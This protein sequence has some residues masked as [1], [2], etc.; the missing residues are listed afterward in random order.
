MDLSAGT[1]EFLDRYHAAMPSDFFHRGVAAQRSLYLSLSDVFPYP[2]PEGVDVVDL[3]VP[4]QT[5]PIRFRVYRPA[6]HPSRAWL[7]YMHGGGFVVGSVESHDTLVAELAANTGLVTVSVEFRLAPEN[8]FPAALEDCREV[9]RAITADPT[10]IGL[11]S[12]ASGPVVCGD[13][14]GANL[15]VCLSVMCRDQDEAMPV[16]QGLI[17]PVLDFARWYD[18]DPSESFGE[19]MRYYTR[20]YCPSRDVA[21]HAYVSPLLSA[22]LTGLPPAYVMSTEYDDLRSDATAYAERL[23]AAG[24]PVHLVVEPGLVHAPVRGRSLIPQVADG[25]RRFCTAVAALAEQ[26]VVAR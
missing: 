17:G 12:N 16:G 10:S 21:D 3:T 20:A 25:W 26:G 9:L 18:P 14:S 15:A 6:G 8:P 1:D 11:A 13:S 19:E 23:H 4:H 7:M 24:V 5:A 22:D 2:R